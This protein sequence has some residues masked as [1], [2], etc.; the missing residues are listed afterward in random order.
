MKNS[1]QL[2]PA[3]TILE[4]LIS[5]IIIT[6]SIIPILKIHSSQNEQIVYL[7]ERNSRTLSDSL[8]LSKDILRYHKS[9]KSAYDILENELKINSLESRR[10]LKKDARNISIPPALI[11]APPSEVPGP[12]FMVQEVKL[13]GQ[14]SANYWHFEIAP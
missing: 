8:Y 12:S 13:K 7:S 11:I 5:V 14:H 2:R 9:T 6:T 4:I 1:S 10:I 3:F